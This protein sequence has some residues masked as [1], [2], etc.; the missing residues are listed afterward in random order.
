M[1][2]LTSR[3]KTKFAFMK[4]LEQNREGTFIFMP[5]NLVVSNLFLTFVLLFGRQA[6]MMGR[7]FQ[8]FDLLNSNLHPE[9]AS[10]PSQPSML[11][12]GHGGKNDVG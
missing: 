12:Y 4:E 5:K 9:T 6:P 2:V 10:V 3:P 7:R 1:N 8:F 11:P